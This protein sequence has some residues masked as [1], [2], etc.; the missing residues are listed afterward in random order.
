LVTN[1]T[2]SGNGRSGRQKLRNRGVTWK[3]ILDL[4][5][6]P[7][8]CL[9]PDCLKGSRLYPTKMYCLATGPKQQTLTLNLHNHLGKEGFNSGYAIVTNEAPTILILKSRKHFLFLLTV[10]FRELYSETEIEAQ[11]LYRFAKIQNN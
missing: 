6:P 1:L 11:C 9:T 7:S 4:S 5:L 2:V 10:L 8:I 3:R